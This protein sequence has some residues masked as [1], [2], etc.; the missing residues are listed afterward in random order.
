MKHNIAEVAALQPDYLGFIFYEKSLRNFEG[1]IPEIPYSTKKV[2]VFVNENIEKVI[3]ITKKQLLDVV[4]LHGEES[5]DYCK[6]LTNFSQDFEIWKAFSVDE[7]FNFEILKP[8][9]TFVSKF[10]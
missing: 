8:Y 6:R 2:G 5:P 7:A 4:Q 10:L 9:E 1:E 3:E